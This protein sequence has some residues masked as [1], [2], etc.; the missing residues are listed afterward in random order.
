LVLA[1]LRS[2][3]SPDEQVWTR[4]RSSIGFGKAFIAGDSPTGAGMSMLG[5]S[6][7]NLNTAR[8]GQSAADILGDYREL[9]EKI[10]KR[11]WLVSDPSNA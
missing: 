1:S 6:K 11:G 9:P 2:R 8:F 7:A 3:I 4:K 5:I 10:S